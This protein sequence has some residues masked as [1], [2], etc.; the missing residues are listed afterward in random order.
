MK[1]NIPLFKVFM[2]E[3]APNAAADVL[4]SGYIGQGPKVDELEAYVSELFNHDFVV[5]TNSATSAEH[6][7]LHLLKAAAVN[8]KVIGGWGSTESKWPG[9]QPGD[10]V[11]ATA[12]TCTATN[13]PILANNLRIKWVDVDPDTMNMDLDDLARKISPTTKAIQIVHWGG[14]PMDMDALKKIQEDALAR[15]GFKPAILEDCAH[16]MGATHKDRMIGTTG[17]IATFSLQA[18]KHITAVDGGLLFLPNED[19][20]KRAKLLRWYGIDRDSN[21]KDFRCEA[22]IEEWGFK[23]HMNDVNAAVGLENFKH[24]DKIVGL[25]RSNAEFFDKKFE[26][27][28]DITLLKKTPNSLG[29]YWLYT[30]K[31]NRRDDFMKYMASCGITVSRVHERNDL[32]T[33]VEEFRTALPSL[34]KTIR[35]MICIPNGWWVTKED[36]EYIAECVLKG[37]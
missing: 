17:N 16:A 19:L 3:E 35:D 14:Q 15:F 28:S 33:C 6:L 11:L 24:L 34:E 22:N 30:I 1:K 9:F 18:I 7:A 26:D 36:R 25:H 20:Y 23:F 31:V 12:L 29:A 4:K 21:R 5:T 10:E 37:W 8:Q 27:H 2:S 32:H 13:W